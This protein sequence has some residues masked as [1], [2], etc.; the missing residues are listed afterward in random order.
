MKFSKKTMWSKR[1][2]N[3]IFIFHN[4]VPI[5]K[6]WLSKKGN[7]TQPSLLFN[8]Y[9]PNECITWQRIKRE[10]QTKCYQQESILAVLMTWLKV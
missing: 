9:L 6:S 8:K 5:Y 10:E 4:G 2:D 3:H 7:K 1:V